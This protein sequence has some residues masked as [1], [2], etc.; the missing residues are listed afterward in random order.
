MGEEQDVVMA[1]APPMRKYRE[2]IKARY[3]DANPQS[4]EDWMELEDKYA[5]D[6]EGELS[7]F[8]DADMTIQEAM[9]AYPE[10]GQLLNDIFVNHLPIRVAIAKNFSQEDLIPSEGDED[11]PDYN[12]VLS[13]RKKK[14][15][16]QSAIDAEIESNVAKSLEDIDAYAKEKGYSEDRKQNLIDF[17]NNTFQDLLMKRID[18][19]VIM[20]FDKAMNY[21]KDIEDA[22]AQAEIAG[23]NAAIDVKKA[24]AN[25]MTDGIPNVAAKGGSIKEVMPSQAARIF[26]GVGERKGI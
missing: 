25:E 2:K 12:T 17:V 4:E 7:K 18:R 3:A 23:K 19:K 9:T 15:E 1:E 21:D 24:Q 26:K 8:K 6:V 20:A 11:Y 5:E 13:E 16:E 14:L 22:K 10:F